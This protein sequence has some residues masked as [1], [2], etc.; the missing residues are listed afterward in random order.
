MIVSLIKSCVLIVENLEHMKNVKKIKVTS[1][2]TITDILMCFFP[3]FEQ[4][5]WQQ[6]N[7][8][9]FKTSST[10]PNSSFPSYIPAHSGLSSYSACAAPLFSDFYWV[11][12]N[13]PRYLLLWVKYVLQ[14][15]VLKSY[16]CIWPYL[17]IKLRSLGWV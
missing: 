7:K 12:L 13:S 17:E 14:K 15:D 4:I 10:V 2:S 9:S 5:F 16:L 8:A 1:D 6:F 11:F 3:D